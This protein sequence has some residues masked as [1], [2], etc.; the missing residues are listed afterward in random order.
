MT[1]RYSLPIQGVVNQRN[2]AVPDHVLAIRSRTVNKT[3]TV[4]VLADSRRHRT[5]LMCSMCPVSLLSVE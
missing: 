3:K 1:E 2:L 4:T 5:K